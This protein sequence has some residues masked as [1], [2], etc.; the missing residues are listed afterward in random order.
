MRNSFV[1]D[2]PRGTLTRSL[3]FSLQPRDRWKSTRQIY[4][5][6]IVFAVI[7]RRADTFR[8]TGAGSS[9]IETT[10]FNEPGFAFRPGHAMRSFLRAPG[11]LF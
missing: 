8:T 1:Q 6:E 10:A 11:G 2:Q 3:W 4:W 7:H 9:V 5:R